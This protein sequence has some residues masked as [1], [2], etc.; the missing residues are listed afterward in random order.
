V[1]CFVDADWPLIAPPNLFR[2]IRLES[3][4]SL[5]GTLAASDR[6]DGSSIARLMGVL[7]TALPPT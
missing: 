7:A 6:L 5:H 1:L 2:G 4:R 3:E